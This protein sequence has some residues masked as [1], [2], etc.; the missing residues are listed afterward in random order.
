MNGNES[1]HFTITGRFRR[2]H[3]RYVFPSLMAV[4]DSLLKLLH[5]GSQDVSF[6]GSLCRN[7]RQV[8]GPSGNHSAL[9]RRTENY[10]AIENRN[11]IEILRSQNR[12]VVGFGHFRHAAGRD[13][14]N[15]QYR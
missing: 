12:Q 4:R 6:R 1:F 15:F 13:K 5:Q 7:I 11:R 9:I 14:C 8:G 3:K 10:M 2:I